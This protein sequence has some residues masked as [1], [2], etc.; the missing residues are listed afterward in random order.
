MRWGCVGLDYLVFEGIPSDEAILRGVLDL[1]VLIFQSDNAATLLEQLP[2]RN[3]L[4]VIVAVTDSKVVGFKIGYE[5]NPRQFHSWLGGVHPDFRR[6]GIGA[7]LM[8]LQHQWCKAHGY[9]CIRTHTRNK[10]R[11]MLIL[12][13]RNGFDVVGTVTENG[14]PKI[15]LEKRL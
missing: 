3:A 8:R 15:I 1:N 9:T 6:K 12:N 5:Q 10:W 2:K 13:I 11:D 7:E 4:L 14:E